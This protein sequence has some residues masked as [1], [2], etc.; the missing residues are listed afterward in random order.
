MKFIVGWQKPI[1]VLAG[2][3]WLAAPSGSNCV[4]V[5]DGGGLAN[6]GKL[7]RKFGQ[8][9][10]EGTEKKR[11]RRGRKTTTASSH[12]W[13]SVGFLPSILPPFPWSFP[14]TRLPLSTTFLAMETDGYI[15]AGQ[16]KGTQNN[17]PLWVHLLPTIQILA[18]R[19]DAVIYFS[20]FS[21]LLQFH[22]ISAT[23]AITPPPHTNPIL[24]P[25]HPSFPPPPFCHYISS[26]AWRRRSHLM[27]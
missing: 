10:L 17:F 20:P 11:A 5:G 21:I 24:Q 4:E 2:I 26:F 1:D 7:N 22:S 6:M 15:Y 12:R 25:C 23:P 19:P 16:G 8:E 18:P 14:G 3:D 27:E 13:I 9:T